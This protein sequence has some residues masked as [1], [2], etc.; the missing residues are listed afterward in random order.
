MRIICGRPGSSVAE[1][2]E[3]STAWEARTV[4]VVAQ[5]DDRLAQR[6]ATASVRGGR[7]PRT[8]KSVRGEQAKTSSPAPAPMRA[9]AGHRQIHTP[10]VGR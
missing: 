5:R 10:E 6:Q 1:R 2:T 8:G 3:R 7:S 4:A 9:P